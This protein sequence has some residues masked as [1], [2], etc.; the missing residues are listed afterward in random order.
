METL[1]IASVATILIP[2][3][4]QWIKQIK[5][6]GNGFAPVVAIVLGLLCG[7]GGYYGGFIEQGTTL[8]EAIMTGIS[9]GGTSTG[10]YSIAKSSI[11]A[12]T[13]PVE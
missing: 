9:I 4:T 13:P 10:L 8:T 11:K 12:V 6:I 5:F 1:T 2:I 3:L 7:L